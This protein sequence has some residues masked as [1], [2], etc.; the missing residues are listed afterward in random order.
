MSISLPLI[1]WSVHQISTDETI[2]RRRRQAEIVAAVHQS[3][4]PVFRGVERACRKFLG[5]TVLRLRFLAA[6]IPGARFIDGNNSISTDTNGSTIGNDFVTTG[7]GNDTISTHAGD[8]TITG[9]GGADTLDGGAGDDT[10]NLASG[11]FAAGESI[12]G[13]TGG[14]QIVL[15]TS[16]NIIDFTTGTLS[17]IETL[18]GSNGDD[19]LTLSA[20]QYAAF[21]TIDLGSG[22]DYINVNVTGAVDISGANNP[23]LVSVEGLNLTGSNGND[24]ITLSGEQLNAFASSINLG[25]GTDTISLTSTSSVL[26]G[27]ADGSLI[28]VEV[29]SAAQAFGVNINLANQSEGFTITGSGFADTLIGGA[30]NDTLVAAQNDTLLDGGIGSDTLNVGAAF[31]STGNAQIANIENLLLTAAVT[32][33]LS[34]QTEGFSIIGSSGA[35][36]ITGGGDVDSINGQAGNDT[37]VGGAGG[38]RIIGGTGADI[39]TVGLGADQFIYTGLTE[40][41]VSPSG[42]DSILDFSSA[43]GDQINLSAIDAVT[44]GSDDAFTFTN[45]F[46][47]I[48]G[49]LISVASGTNFIVQGDTNGDGIADFAIRVS[50]AATAP[51]SSDFIL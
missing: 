3:R 26:N 36:R 32:L 37:I 35:D 48:S 33:N 9:G 4:A 13:G 8:D 34:N 51:T 50:N 24:S 6:K 2:Y 14:D 49:E 28:N 22:T 1:I 21:S 15:T 16:G 11:D 44:R 17:G 30:G 19:G 18:I 20:A 7:S 39:L 23:T 38:D 41:T 31:T 47:H 27:L 12:A 10:F 45:V 46:H 43:Q 25:G 42:R 40:S 29:I 5:L